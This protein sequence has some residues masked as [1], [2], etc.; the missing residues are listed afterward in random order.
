MIGICGDCGV[1]LHRLALATGLR[2]HQIVSLH[3]L[4]EQMNSWTMIVYLA[5]AR[6]LARGEEIARFVASAH[7]MLIAVVPAERRA[8]RDIVQLAKHD[9]QLVIAMQGLCSI[10]EVIVRRRKNRRTET[11]VHRVLTHLATHV[12]SDHALISAA[13]ALLGLRRVRADA[14]P[15]WLERPERSV[16]RMLAE[17]GLPSPSDYPALFTG[18]YVAFDTEVLDRSFRDVAIDRGFASTDE[19]RRYLVTRTGVSPT[20]W[21][22]LGF[23]RALDLATF[24]RVRA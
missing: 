13:A 16:R 6:A 24:P 3:E 12:G 5:G 23:E 20:A 1:V 18:A 11:P 2:C 10:E 22:K 19:L 7:C 9:G 8:L 14:L 17:A 4:A 15:H 21:T